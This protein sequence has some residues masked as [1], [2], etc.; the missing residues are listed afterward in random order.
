MLAD[1][2][3]SYSTFSQLAGLILLG[4]TRGGS[5]G[6]LGE[7]WAKRLATAGFSLEERDMPSSEGRKVIGR[8]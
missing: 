1:M 2:R 4:C 5:P 6:I 8:V 7:P 3:D